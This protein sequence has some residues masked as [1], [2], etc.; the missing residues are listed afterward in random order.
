MS[1]MILQMPCATAAIGIVAAAP[2]FVAL[3]KSRPIYS[4]LSRLKT[5]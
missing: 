1:L 3:I 4:G 5:P 2:I